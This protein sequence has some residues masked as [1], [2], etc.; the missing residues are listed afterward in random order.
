MTHL[1]EPTPVDLEDDL[2]DTGEQALHKSNGPLLERLG[3]HSVVGVCEH[4]HEN[5]VS[6]VRCYQ[7]ICVRVWR[8]A[9]KL[10]CC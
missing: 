6:M 8:S 4:L 2:H 3:E 10:C 5:K 7:R 9:G 1:V